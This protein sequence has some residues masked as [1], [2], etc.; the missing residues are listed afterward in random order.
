MLIE[1]PAVYQD[2][3]ALEA[4]LDSIMPY[5]QNNT[6]TQLNITTNQ[7]WVLGD[8]QAVY[9]NFDKALKDYQ[10]FFKLDLSTKKLKALQQQKTMT[11]LYYNRLYVQRDFIR[12]RPAI[13]ILRNTTEILHYTKTK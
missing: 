12:K 7:A 8:L 11:N 13:G 6:L 3:K 10:R 2:V 1:N 5:Y 9:A 4:L